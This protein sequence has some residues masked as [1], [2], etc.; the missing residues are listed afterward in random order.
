MTLH[1]C[2]ST[3]WDI[4]CFEILGHIT[5]WHMTQRTTHLD[6]LQS[7]DNKHYDIWH[8]VDILFNLHTKMANLSYSWAKTHSVVLDEVNLQ[9]SIFPWVFEFFL[10]LIDESVTHCHWIIG[11]VS[12][13]SDVVEACVHSHK[14]LV[15]YYHVVQDYACFHDVTNVLRWPTVYRSTGYNPSFLQDAKSSFN[16]LSSGLLNGG[17]VLD[18]NIIWITDCLDK[19]W[20]VRINIIC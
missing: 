14:P 12:Q 18:P 13:D 7:S 15:L 1:R 2:C 16:I 3:Q 8:N 6:K 11:S 4:T 20:P 10:V 19:H 9:L 5:Q 17:K